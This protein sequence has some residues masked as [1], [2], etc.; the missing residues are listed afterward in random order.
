MNLLI[1]NLFYSLLNYL[2]IVDIIHMMKK[3]YKNDS[4]VLYFTNFYTKLINA[5]MIYF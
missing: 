4:L 3:S 5:N 1:V 2:L